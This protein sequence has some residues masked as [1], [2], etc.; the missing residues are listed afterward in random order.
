[1]NAPDRR[2]AR[3]DK[4][5]HEILSRPPHERAAALTAACPDDPELATEVRSLLDQP[6][7]AAG[8]MATPVLDVVAR[9]VSR[10]HSAHTGQRIGVFELRDLLAVGGMGEVYRARDT[11]LGRDVAIKVL[12]EAFAHDQERLGRFNREAQALASLNHP[13]IAVIYGVEEMPATSASDPGSR[14]LVME[15]VEGEDLS[16]RI[17]RGPLP[18]NEALPIARQIAKALEAAHA[19]GIVHRDLKPA[20]IKIRADGTVK[21]LDFG[22]AKVQSVA[23]DEPAGPF[24]APTRDG[25]VM[26]TPGYMSPEQIRGQ[27]VDWRSDLFALGVVLYEMLAGRRAFA[28]GSDV[29]TMGATLTEAPPDLTTLAPNTDP[30]LA[31]AVERCLEKRPGD[32]FQSAKDLGATLGALKATPDHPFTVRLPR[33][34]WRFALLVAA[35]ITAIAT[36]G[37][38][39]SRA[40]RPP[41]PATFRQVTSDG[42]SVVGDLSPD[43]KSLAYVSGREGSARLL[44]RDLG[45]G[46]AVELFG[47]ARLG[48]P[49][50]SNSGKFIALRRTSADG[51]SDILVIS[52]FGGVPV[53]TF[54][55]GGAYK[56]SWSPDDSE[57][58]FG[59]LNR[60][61]FRVASLGTGQIRRIEMNSPLDGSVTDVSP[62]GERL[63][64]CVWHQPNGGIWSMKRDGTGLIKHASERRRALDARWSADGA[65]IYYVTIGA[66]VSEVRRARVLSD[67]PDPSPVLVQGNLT[68]EDGGNASISLSRNGRLAYPRL[69]FDRNIWRADIDPGASTTAPIPL[70]AVTS[71]VRS[72][73]P[74][75]SPD[76]TRMVFTRQDGELGQL[77]LA[78]VEGAIER[79]LVSRKGL[80]EEPAWSPDGEGIA[81]SLED[82]SGRTLHIVDVRS[83]V[84]REVKPTGAATHT[85]WAPGP[86]IL[87][88]A[89]GAWIHT[90]DPTTK[91]DAPLVTPEEGGSLLAPRY[92]NRGDRVALIHRPNTGT[93]AL[94]VVSIQD[95]RLTGILRT[96]GLLRPLGWSADDALVYV[97]DETSNQLVAVR[98]DGKG[99]RGMGTFP[100]HWM[101]G[102]ARELSGKLRLALWYPNDRA[103]I[104]VVDNFDGGR[105]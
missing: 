33:I 63:L 7:S 25:A 52:R 98:A 59:N 1:M 2:W 89:P 95:R 34:H 73:D 29:E 17:A 46:G 85:E 103:D 35:V 78:S 6:G 64:V 82:D 31:A 32:R 55:P 75:F 100:S 39:F 87:Y 44:V 99:V 24:G 38:G 58:I 68:I 26:G 42:Q 56:I 21:V 53:R 12:S 16:A 11:K 27:A 14:A 61:W 67:G 37:I 36:L 86:L 5:Y 9:E 80:A 66:N 23:T 19:Q 20:N 41:A 50:W 28:K 70:R 62:D 8:F 91:N 105:R 104:W 101:F 81:Y 94:A 88:R 83:G 18:T 30:A 72:E 57:L 92:S 102:Q 79:T 65:S 22:L 48:A 54:A 76:G 10:S 13:N 97:I 60:R 15:L 3:I 4:L 40:T 71:G 43:G 96:P 49:R 51:Q 45:G 47:P 74:R 93:A 77:L 69:A 90:L 84:D